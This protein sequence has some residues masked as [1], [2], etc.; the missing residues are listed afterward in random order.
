MA[1]IEGLFR[2]NLSGDNAEKITDRLNKLSISVI[3]AE[4]PI[5][6]GAAIHMLKR[7]TFVDSPPD[8]DWSAFGIAAAIWETGLR[9]DSVGHRVFDPSFCLARWRTDIPCVKPANYG[10]YIRF[11]KFKD[12]ES[13]DEFSSAGKAFVDHLTKFPSPSAK[14]ADEVAFAYI[15]DVL[16]PLLDRSPLRVAQNVLNAC[17]LVMLWAEMSMRPRVAV[18]D[19]QRHLGGSEANQGAPDVKPSTAL[20]L[21][22]L[23]RLPKYLLDKR[24][25]KDDFGATGHLRAA[26][27]KLNDF[28]RRM[29]NTRQEHLDDFFDAVMPLLGG[30]THRNRR[31]KPTDWLATL[32]FTDQKQAYRFEGVVED[33]SDDGNGYHIRLHASIQCEGYGNGQSIGST[34]PPV[35]SNAVKLTRE[36]RHFEIR[37]VSLNIRALQ[38]DVPDFEIADAWLLRGW[39]YEVS[40]GKYGNDSGVVVWVR[41]SPPEVVQRIAHLPYLFGH[42]GGAGGGERAEEPS[43]V[44][45]IVPPDEHKGIVPPPPPQPQPQPN[46]K[47]LARAMKRR[48]ASAIHRTLHLPL[49]EIDLHLRSIR[50][51]LKSF[52]ASAEFRVDHSAYPD[53]LD[54]LN[55]E[56]LEILILAASRQE[57]LKTPNTLQK[58]LSKY[59]GSQSQIQNV[60]QPVPTGTKVPQ[61]PGW[62][63]TEADR[64]ENYWIWTCGNGHKVRWASRTNPPQSCPKCK[65]QSTAKQN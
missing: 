34:Q 30:W 46:I 27:A 12:L 23:V 65:A 22:S 44:P 36:N 40:Y 61:T 21:N 13:S 58:L 42:S 8:F 31:R 4:C 47:A 62:W 7:L 3:K 16:V 24:Y 28:R 38:Q 10:G 1:E 25:R 54:R 20:C 6:S 57:E 26:Y 37:Q 41:A 15:E 32:N 35:K 59:H 29:P 45:S 18:P 51:H 52:V 9:A 5:V 63:L 50:E 11:L 39:R 64:E 33:V 49:T 56:Q 48:I 55:E 14:A 53:R 19:N 2:P 17:E 43:T 60:L